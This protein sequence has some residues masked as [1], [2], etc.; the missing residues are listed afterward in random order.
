MK[1]MLLP[2]IFV[3]L[4]QLIMLLCVCFVPQMQLYWLIPLG[5]SPLLLLFFHKKPTLPSAQKNFA[6][7]YALALA[8]CSLLV[9]NNAIYCAKLFADTDAFVF[10]ALYF[11]TFAV[12]VTVVCVIAT[13]LKRS[14]IWFALATLVAIVACLPFKTLAM[15]I[16]T[17]VATVLTMSFVLSSATV[18]GKHLDDACKLLDKQKTHRKMLLTFCAVPYCVANVFFLLTV[19]LGSSDGVAV[20]SLTSDIVSVVALF[21]L[22]FV[23]LRNPMDF[24]SLHKMKLVENNVEDVDCQAVRQQ[25]YDRLSNDSNYSFAILLKYTLDKLLKMKVVGMEKVQET[26][27][28]FVANH[29][30]VYGPFITEAKFPRVFRPWTESMIVNKKTLTRQLKSGIEIS[31]RKWLIKP[32]RRRIAPA[33]AY[34]LWRVVN[35]ARPIAVYRNDAEKM[36]NMLKET[37]DAM[38]TGDSVMIFPEKPPAGQNYKNGDIDKLQTGFTEIAPLFQQK[39]GKQMNFYPLFIDKKHC[40]MIVGEKVTFNPSNQPH[41]EKQR[42]AEQ[43][44]N[45]LKKLSEQCGY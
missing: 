20:A 36:E 6:V 43:L 7:V 32:V 30:E 23:H 15:A 35:C 10:F 21:V 2:C 19:G 3:L 13:L 9:S 27:A 18:C 33:V 28:C 25:L 11:A 1:G 44:Y 38:T 42:I 8:F 4:L 24:V 5:I 41:E 39:T 16:V 29:Y 31:T 14:G 45:E 12:A 34:V 26:G 17:F 40:R 37:V 22:L